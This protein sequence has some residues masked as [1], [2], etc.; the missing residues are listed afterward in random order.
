MKDDFRG[1]W[2]SSFC[3]IEDDEEDDEDEER[4][5]ELKNRVEGDD[6]LSFEGEEIL[7]WED[8]DGLGMRIEF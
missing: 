5:G 7:N 6:K 2:S 8:L 1:L 4:H 3:F